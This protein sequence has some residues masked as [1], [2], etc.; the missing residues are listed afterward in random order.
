MCYDINN[1]K[2][3]EID[4]INGKIVELSKKYNINLPINTSLYFL[5]KCKESTF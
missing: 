5:I 2:H 3:S 1:N 4:F